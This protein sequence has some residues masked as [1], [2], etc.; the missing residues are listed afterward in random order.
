MIVVA[1]KKDQ[2]C[3][4]FSCDSCGE[5]IRDAAMGVAV[6]SLG[7]PEASV[8]VVKHAHKGACHRAVEAEFSSPGWDE[9]RQH[10][11]YLV[12]NTKTTAD[13]HEKAAW[14]SGM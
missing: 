12:H 10:V 9:L 11:A 3:P 14:A 6:S 1:R 7:V 4:M 2:S 13:D 8:S 5:L